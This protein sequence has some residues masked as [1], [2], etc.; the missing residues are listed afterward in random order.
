M[1]SV[2]SLGSQLKNSNG[3]G[4]ASLAAVLRAIARSEPPVV[5][6]HLGSI[7]GLSSATISN[8]VGDLISVRLLTQGTALADGPGRPIV[9]LHWSAEHACLGVSLR[10]KH[11]LPFELIG[12]ATTLGGVPVGELRRRELTKRAQTDQGLLIDEVAAFIEQLRDDCSERRC[13]VLGAGLALGGHVDN[14]TI[15]LSYNTGWGVKGRQWAGL[16][17]F[18]LSTLLQES[19]GIRVVVDNDVNALAIHENLY[20]RPRTNSYAVVA[21]M[22][23]GI[24]GGLILQGKP[25]RGYRGMAGEIGHV[26]VDSSPDAI[27]CRCGR[28]GCVEVYATPDAIR[29]QTG[30]RRLGDIARRAYTD[31]TANE[32]FQRGGR[33]LGSGIAAL[34]NWMNLGALIVYLPPSMWEVEPDRAGRAYIRQL[35]DTL[36]AEVF[37]NGSEIEIDFRCISLTEVE[38]RVAV[39]AA[40]LVLEQTIEALE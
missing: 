10:D 23:D 40:S 39:A 37:S 35:S 24:G 27:K 25:W 20:A 2:A 12:T 7:L 26:N 14:G 19:T 15:R 22:P 6:R 13:T 32:A 17:D 29:R 28:Y 1:D 21:V 36:R 31:A 9:P 5:R 11:G 18:P 8:A 38:K 33:A 3:V 30:T 34:L 16:D 4:G